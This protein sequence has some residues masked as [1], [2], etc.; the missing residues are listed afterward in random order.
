MTVKS[1]RGVIQE[2]CDLLQIAEAIQTVD[3]KHL[4]DKLRARSNLQLPT[5]KDDGSTIDVV[6]SKQ[7]ASLE[8]VRTQ[9]CQ[10]GTSW[11]CDNMA[12]ALCHD[13]FHRSVYFMQAAMTRNPFVD[14][15]NM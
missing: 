15:C 6:S 7:A 5:C 2:F 13:S 4:L 10:S 12:H 3:G 9:A 14:E 11:L 1:G 8:K